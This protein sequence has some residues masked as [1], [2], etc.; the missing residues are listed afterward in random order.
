MQLGRRLP[1]PP[2]LPVEPPGLWTLFAHQARHRPDAVAAVDDGCSL[3]Y[4]QLHE[5]AL[6]RAGAL[7]GAG[8][9]AG[10]AVAVYLPNGLDWMAAALAADRLGA[11]LV[12]VNV[13]FRAPEIAGLLASLRPKVVVTTDAFLT[14]PLRER[15]TSAIESVADEDVALPV[16]Q[17]VG[18]GVLPA[19]SGDALPS[20][21]P[22]AET[23]PFVV[24][25]TSGS[26]GRPKGVVH[27]RAL[28]GNVWNWVRSI[29]FGPQ[30]RVLATRPFY[31]IAGAC[32]NL[33][34]V[35]ATGGCVVVGKLFT[36]EEMA[37]ALIEQGVTIM[38]GGPAVFEALLARADFVAAAE[39]GLPVR[40]TIVGGAP[41]SRPL[42]ER[43]NAAFPA[44]PLVQTYG[45]TELRGYMMSTLPSDDV[46]V[47]FAT[48]GGLLPGFEVQLRRPDGSRIET[49][50]EIGQL[51]VRGE[52]LAD[53]TL[54]GRHVPAREADGWFA[55]GDLL[56][57]RSDGNWV[58]HSRERE[59]AKVR[60]E[61]VS[62]SSVD[63]ALAELPLIARAVT[64]AIPVEHGDRL[65]A[66]VELSA[67]ASEDALL[68]AARERMAPFR[69]P[70]RIWIK[71]PSLPWPT[72]PSGKISRVLVAESLASAPTWG[73]E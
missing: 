36:D 47:R 58:F 70:A 33:F 22:R 2:P 54:D 69:V 28:I 48:V 21:P 42:F 17:V 72:L 30:D 66:V 24:F 23:D 38:S 1:A 67:P 8:V 3:T 18:D 62:L 55:T 6:A 14:N 60:G 34:G 31:Y 71:P 27:T 19:V 53:Y 56:A 61:S 15:L 44:A 20:R 57:C 29:G 64:V 37:T 45:M 39:A 5:R 26:T 68:A 43:I 7:A 25:W 4:A 73:S 9:A 12:P 11:V 63:L 51:Y 50:G 35:L 59:I 41:L 10:D 49:A 65:E 40:R 13:R 16:V 46:E 52:I 32:W